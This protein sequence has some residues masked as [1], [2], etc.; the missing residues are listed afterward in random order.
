[1]FRLID[2]YGTSSSS[3]PQLTLLLHST[4]GEPLKQNDRGAWLF[5]YALLS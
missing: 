4:L 5:L 2:Y 3:G 1:V